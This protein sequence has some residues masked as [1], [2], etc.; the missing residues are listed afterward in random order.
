MNFDMR[1]RR[2]LRQ[3]RPVHLRV[4]PKRNFLDFGHIITI[5]NAGGAD[6]KLR[7]TILS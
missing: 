2:V 1:L 5:H 3:L 6:A 4:L 7:T